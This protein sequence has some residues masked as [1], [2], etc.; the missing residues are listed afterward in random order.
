MDETNNLSSKTWEELRALLKALKSAP[1][2]N[3]AMIVG[4][5]A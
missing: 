1:E 2:P 3:R 5:W 4:S